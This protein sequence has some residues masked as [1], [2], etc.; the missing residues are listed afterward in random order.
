MDPLFPGNSEMDQWKRILTILGYPNEN[1]GVVF[2]KL[3]S[4]SMKPL[5]NLP[6]KLEKI[7][8]NN[9]LTESGNQMLKNFLKYDPTKRITSDNALLIQYINEPE[10]A[11]GPIIFHASSIYAKS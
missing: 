7:F 2:D 3:M 8:S 5:D 9:V 4:L 10:M 1:D 6:P 11:T